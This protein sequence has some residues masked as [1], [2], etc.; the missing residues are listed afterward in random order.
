MITDLMRNDL[1][2]ICL[3]GTIVVNQLYECEAYT[4]VF[5]LISKI[6]GIV[7]GINPIE[8]IR[9]CYPGG[10]ITGCPKLKAMEVISSIEK[11]PRGIYTGSIGYFTGDGDFDFNLAIRTII[12]DKN[13]VNI[14]LGGG[15]VIDSKPHN[16][17]LE[18]LHKGS[19]IFTVLSEKS[20]N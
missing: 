12:F 10:S 6:S 14:Q 1:G 20:E 7:K 5:N 4:N 8:I 19:S 13:S 18:T 15:I 2:K 9:A 17:Y 11:R 16:E 3:P